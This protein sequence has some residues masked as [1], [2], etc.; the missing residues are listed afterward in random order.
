MLLSFYS[1]FTH[2]NNLGDMHVANFMESQTEQ[3]P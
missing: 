1:W 2:E 3:F